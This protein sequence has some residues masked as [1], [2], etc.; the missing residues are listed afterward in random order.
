LA[1]TA[2]INIVL[3]FFNLIPLPPLDG[4][5]ILMN[6]FPGWFGRFRGVF[7]RYGFIATLI[8]IFFIWQFLT[9]V[10]LWLFRLIVGV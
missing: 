2:L 9:P 1:L 4:S 7:E 6:V 8:F 10:I 3:A 5:K